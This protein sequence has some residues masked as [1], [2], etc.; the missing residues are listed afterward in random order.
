MTDATIGAAARR[1]L[2]LLD[3][4]DGEFAARVYDGDLGRYDRRLAQY[5][6]R[7]MRR[8]L[9]AGAGVGQWSIALAATNEAVSAVEIDPRRVSFIEA[10]HHDAGLGNIEASQGSVTQLDFAD[11]A[12]DA[13]YCYGVVEQTPWKSV[14]AEFAR[15]LAPGGTLYLNAN[16]VG[17]YR[18]LW[19]TEHN[20]SQNYDPR[21]YAAR[22]FATTI[23]YERG[24][25]VVFPSPV[26]ISPEDLRGELSALG[27]EILGAG[28]EGTVVAAG[29]APSGDRPF[30]LGEYKS[31]PCVHE[32]LARRL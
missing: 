24:E 8:V 2:G 14:L 7:G 29:R 15:V 12:F 28:G 18:F 1:H 31:D 22:A 27:F 19:D 3:G 6:F 21:A 30:F 25:A 26:I 4:S 16:G 17:W 11:G 5:G 32:V 23:A 9:D 13:V 10:M 20:R